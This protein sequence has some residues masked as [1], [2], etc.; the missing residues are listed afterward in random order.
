MVLSCFLDNFSHIDRI[1]E[2]STFFKE[3]LS[4]RIGPDIFLQGGLTMSS[5]SL[6][7]VP[8]HLLL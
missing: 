4:F 7:C 5:T 6:S 2:S 8:L 1:D 3:M